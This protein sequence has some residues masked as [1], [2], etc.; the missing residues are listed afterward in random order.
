VVRELSFLHNI[1]S[2]SGVGP[3]SYHI[4]TE[5]PLFVGRAAGGMKVIIHHH[6]EPRLRLTE[7]C[8]ICLH[9]MML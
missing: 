3:A 2:M 6:L 9:G 1:Q 5:S 4:R 8:L 7:L